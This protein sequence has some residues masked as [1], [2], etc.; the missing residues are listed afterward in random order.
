M[1]VSFCSLIYV[2]FPPLFFIFFLILVS[3]NFLNY[4]IRFGGGWLGVD[5]F[6][7]K[8]GTYNF[9]STN[10]LMVLLRCCCANCFK[11]VYGRTELFNETKSFS[12]ND[13]M[14]YG[15]GN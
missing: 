12:P 4:F 6:L 7:E 14:Q 2:S 15:L 5:S 3:F 1:I 13:R 8:Y 11:H 10:F 9:S